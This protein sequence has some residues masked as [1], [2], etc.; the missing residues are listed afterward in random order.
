MARWS[1][2]RDLSLKLCIPC[3]TSSPLR[4]E[5]RVRETI[6]LLTQPLSFSLGRGVFKELAKDKDRDRERVMGR[7]G[8]K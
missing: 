2:R 1:T 8:W 5:I 7:K 4:E 3:D 6:D